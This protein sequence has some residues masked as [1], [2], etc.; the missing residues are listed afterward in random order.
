MT[1]YKFT[2]FLLFLGE[3]HKYNYV[4]LSNILYK[5]YP[6]MKFCSENLFN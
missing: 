1:Q 4:D 6:D 5:F 3:G 2:G